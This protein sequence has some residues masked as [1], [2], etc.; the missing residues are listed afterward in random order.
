MNF[1]ETSIANVAAD[2]AVGLSTEKPLSLNDYL[3]HGLTQEEAELAARWTGSTVRFQSLLMRAEV[4]YVHGMTCQ[5]ISAW[6][7]FYGVSQLLAARIQ[8]GWDEK[9]SAHELV[10][11]TVTASDEAIRDRATACVRSIM[12]HFIEKYGSSIT[13]HLADPISESFPR[14]DQRDL[15]VLTN[16]IKA[17][18]FCQSQSRSPKG[19]SRAIKNIAKKDELMRVVRERDPRLAVQIY[20]A[21]E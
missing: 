1:I 9:R 13:D 17:L 6:L 4:L 18:T 10:H 12:T 16:A 20:N 5:M 14:I 15:K 2:T 7:P 3:D 11:P 19:H 21:V 8:L